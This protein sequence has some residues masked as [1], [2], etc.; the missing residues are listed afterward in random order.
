M[1]NH[2]S[3][4]S[5]P[6]L[7]RDRPRLADAARHQN[8]EAGLNPLLS[9]LGAPATG[10]SSSPS[11]NLAGFYLPE[12]RLIPSTMSMLSHMAPLGAG[13]AGLV[14]PSQPEL[15]AIAQQHMQNASILRSS[16]MEQK[17]QLISYEDQMRSRMMLLPSSP[18]LQAHQMKDS[19]FLMGGMGMPGLFTGHLPIPSELDFNKTEGR[20]MKG[21][22]IEPFPEKLH[23][24]LLEVE[25]A[26]KADII[27]F[28]A[29]GRAFAIHKPDKFCDEIVP[30]YFRQS[31]YNSFKRQLNLYDFMLINSGPHRGGYYHKSFIKNRPDLCRNMRR[32]AVKVPG[33]NQGTI[34]DVEARPTSS[35]SK[36]DGKP[37]KPTF[38]DSK[39]DQQGKE[40]ET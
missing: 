1:N 32:V 8:F 6:F 26:G 11:Q 19:R 3:G 27:S 34:P 39:Q 18:F 35:N 16:I 13:E 9:A 30:R 5:L 22:V 40:Q 4:S 12:S 25:A 29:N 37:G 15:D 20:V 36:Q 10:M 7:S 38:S 14:A 17:L 24:L 21:G 2:N 28:I 23:R 33:S 31:R